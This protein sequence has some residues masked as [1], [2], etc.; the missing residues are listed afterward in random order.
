MNTYVSDTKRIHRKP[1][2]YEPDKLA[3]TTVFIAFVPD[4]RL[5]RPVNAYSNPQYPH[6]AT[7]GDNPNGG[8]TLR[9]MVN[10][11]FKSSCTMYK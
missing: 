7:R 6:G 9:T 10:V 11:D 8:K 2:Q 3:V 5:L 4:A 1:K